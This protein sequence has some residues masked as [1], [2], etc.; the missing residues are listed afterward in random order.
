MLVG[1]CA[2]II[3]M[4]KKST[5]TSEDETSKTQLF[6]RRWW[7]M[8]C[9]GIQNIVL[10]ISYIYIGMN[11]DIFAS[12]FD[13]SYAV[14][15]WFTVV[16]RPAVWLTCVGLAIL[17]IL[18]KSG[19]RKIAITAAL[20]FV[21]ASTFQLVAYIFPFLYWFMFVAN[22]LLGI[23]LAFLIIAPVSFAVLWFPDHEIG[24]AL[25]IKLASSRLGF[26][27]AFL[28][29]S[30][31]LTPLQCKDIVMGTGATN[32]TLDQNYTQCK[33]KWM[34]RESHKLIV[35]VGIILL[36]GV[37]LLI[38]LII[39]AR[40]QPPK[41]PTAAQA[42]LRQNVQ[43]QNEVETW[44]K[45]KEFV[46]ELKPLF[47]DRTFLLLIALLAN[48]NVFNYYQA[49]FL[50]ETL[51]PIF[52]SFSFNANVVS[53]YLI[54]GFEIAAIIST[55]VSGLLTDRIKNYVL[56]LRVG[57]LYC[58]VCWIGLIVGYHFH[59]TAAIFAANI[60]SGAGSGLLYTPIYELSTQHTYP[61]KPEFIGS[62]LIWGYNVI[63]VVEIELNRLLLDKFGGLI[64]L[65][66]VAV[67]LCVFLVFTLF[68]R[69][70]Y[71]RLEAEKKAGE[72]L[73]ESAPLLW[74]DDE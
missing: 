2:A 53:S 34:N 18:N 55:F 31:F 15:D 25:S 54:V 62:C 65:I 4:P 48:A 6:P 46:M 44:T 68:L 35:Y 72:T 43:E 16:T 5:S 22:F 40:D 71:R 63:Y 73:C 61:R 23:M 17:S 27:L 7:L 33:E 9:M 59:N 14:I 60:L 66:Y 37:L 39:F 64:S 8:S 28:G 70:E 1:V 38:F 26:L 3:T 11:N 29:P 10:G 36:I 74:H 58:V 49:M 45:W 56:L 32:L 20:I 19:F 12:Y 41:P 69:P 30:H 13:L 67:I 47:T 42:N 52:Q 51:R 57:V 21:I 50:S 24:T